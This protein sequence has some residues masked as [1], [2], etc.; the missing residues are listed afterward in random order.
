MLS[1]DKIVAFGDGINDV[2]MFKLSD[3]CYAV[4]NAV[5]GLKDIATA[6]IDSNLDDAVAQ[7]LKE[8][9]RG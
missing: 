8:N 1:Y 6:V 3:E 2:E 9:L 4:K 5:E 7:W